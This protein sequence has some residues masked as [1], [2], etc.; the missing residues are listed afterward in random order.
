MVLS[1]VYDYFDNN[2]EAL[3]SWTPAVVLT[4][5]YFVLVLLGKFIMR[6]R[7]PF[8]LKGALQLHN[9]VLLVMSVV[10]LAGA[11]F[12][13]FNSLS[14]HP[15]V[16][17]FCS[18]T[19]HQGS[20]KLS[21]G[22]LFWSYMFYISKFYEFFDTLFIILRKKNLLFLHF[23]HH[24]VV[25]PLSLSFIRHGMFFYLNGVVSNALIHSFM[26]YSY[27][28]TSIGKPPAWKIYLTKAQI[29]QFVWGLGSFFPWPA[30]CGYSITSISGPMFVFWFNQGVLIS[31]FFLFMSFFSKRYTSE[32][33]RRSSTSTSHKTK[34]KKSKKEE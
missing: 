26:Y 21:R 33:E 30:T 25:V 28:K 7:K 1:S 24:M 4:S 10:M 13:I 23:Y 14:T 34:S 5:A 29:V 16:D 18:S 20:Y 2:R 3:T 19:E 22:G 8:E 6:N 17:V 31:F 15:F 27:Y 11:A 12:E 32:E 9:L